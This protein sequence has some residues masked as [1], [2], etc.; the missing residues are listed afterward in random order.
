MTTDATM[1][2]TEQ[3]FYDATIKS[4]DTEAKQTVIVTATTPSRGKRARTTVRR[5]RTERGQWFEAQG[6]VFAARKAAPFT[7]TRTLTANE[8]QEWLGRYQA[9]AELTRYFGTIEIA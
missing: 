1:S 9:R 2:D 8:A 7:V 5:A 3:K 6:K 4:I